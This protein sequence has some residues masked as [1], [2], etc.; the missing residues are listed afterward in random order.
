MESFDK[1]HECPI[2]GKY[3]F[4]HENSHWCCP[5]CGWE[6]DGVMESEPDEWEG[7]PN[8]LCLNEYKARYEKIIA[9]YPNYRFDKDPEMRY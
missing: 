3:K 6:D 7:C 5:Y 4:P 8:D 1:K 9:K 2:C